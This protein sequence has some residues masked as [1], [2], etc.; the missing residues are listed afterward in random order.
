LKAIYDNV[1]MADAPP[2][3]VK[4]DDATQK[5]VIG[6]GGELTLT[7]EQLAEITKKITSIRTMII[8]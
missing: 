4:T 8:S 5:T 3:E 7:P 1:K 6:S 2:A